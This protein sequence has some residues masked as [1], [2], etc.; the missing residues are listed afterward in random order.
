MFQH[1]F[2]Q[3]RA[4]NWNDTVTISTPTDSFQFFFIKLRLK[5]ARVT[6]SAVCLLPVND[7][8]Y[9]RTDTTTSLAASSVVVDFGCP[10]HF[11][12]SLEPKCQKFLTRDLIAHSMGHII[13]NQ[14]ERL[15]ALF[16]SSFCKMIHTERSLSSCEKICRQNFQW[17]TYKNRLLPPVY[18]LWLF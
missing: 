7:L 16:Q 10:L 17:P 9:C 18:K 14:H 12:M 8:G 6:A 15:M 5:H 3:S 1:D 2:S 4:V 11:W 13:L